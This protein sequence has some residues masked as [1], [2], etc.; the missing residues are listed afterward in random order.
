MA[1]KIVAKRTAVLSLDV[2][3]DL[4][5]ITAGI[6]ENKVLD[7]IARVL[8]AAR[9][10]KAPVFHITASAR[11]DFRDVPRN[12]PLWQSIRKSKAMIAGS[13]GAAI[14]PKAAPKGGELIL[15][16]SC[17]DPFLTT[18]LGQQLVNVDAET[19]VVM[20]L[21]TNYVVEATMRHASDMGYRVVV[22]RDACASNTIENHEFAMT[23]IFP[24]L[25]YVV[26]T[27]EVVAALK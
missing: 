17:V 13:K 16:K 8:A 10:N 25:S 15:N 12:S 9:R 2:Q 23:R 11:P 5:P 1:I 3:N 21:W 6:K 20:G 27:A 22:V 4:V 26:S 18:S 14:H 24:T 7:N 19:V